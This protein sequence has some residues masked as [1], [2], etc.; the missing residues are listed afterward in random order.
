MGS[1]AIELGY[2]WPDAEGFTGI[3][4]FVGGGIPVAANYDDAESIIVGGLMWEQGW[5]RD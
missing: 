4:V 2:R 5:W 1:T 3:G